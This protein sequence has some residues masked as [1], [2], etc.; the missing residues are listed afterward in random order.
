MIQDSL[1][2][3]ATH[4]RVFFSILYAAFFCFMQSV[5]DLW[6]YRIGDVAHYFK[7]LPLTIVLSFS[8]KKH[9]FISP[10]RFS[11][12]IPTISVIL[13]FKKEL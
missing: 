2:N 1:F 12:S 4:F 8:F 9:T 13:F 6:S 5:E 7:Y 11:K 10:V 3:P